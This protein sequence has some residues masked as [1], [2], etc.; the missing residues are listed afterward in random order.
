MY[1]ARADGDTIPKGDDQM[2][3][4]E[5]LN[6]VRRE[7]EMGVVGI[8]AVLRY[9]D[10]GDFRMALQGQLAEYNKLQVEATRLLSQRGGVKHDLPQMAKR[11]AKMT[12][13]MKLLQDGSA[14]K[15]AGMM[16]EGNTKGMVKSLRNLR[17]YCGGDLPTATVA[18]RLLET[19]LANI[20]QMKPYL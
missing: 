9:A 12:A 1:C 3:E 5:L 15:I 20:E 17:L 10:D 7:T 4:C 13:R 2:Q 11:C 19:E 18:R 14:S 8:H 16:I 6:A